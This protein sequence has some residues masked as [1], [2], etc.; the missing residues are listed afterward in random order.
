MNQKGKAFGVS[1][2]A[3]HIIAMSVMFVDHI[4]ASAPDLIWMRAIGRLA[5]PI[6]AFLIAEGFYH[7]S[8]VVKYLERLLI[9]GLIS[10]IP[11]DL[12]FFDTVYYPWH[13]NVM[14]TFLLSLLVIWPINYYKDKVHPFIWIAITGF[15]GALGWYAG[16]VL[17]VDY[18]G[19]GVLTVLVFFLFRERGYVNRACQLLLM[20]YINFVMLGGWTVEVNAFGSS[21]IIALQ[22]LAVFSLVLIWLYNG[23]HG[24]YNKTIKYF[25]YSFYPGHLAILAALG[26]LGVL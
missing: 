17:M 8:S 7:T 19:C 4:G 3:L 12:Y 2:F 24:Y 13:Q 6:F 10:E 26:A 23:E 1:G 15:S 16:D 14:W 20:V 25:Y 22:G 9:F 5:F 21:M 18:G 11:F